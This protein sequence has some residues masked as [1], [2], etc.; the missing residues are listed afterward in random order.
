MIRI[1]ETITINR[2]VEEVFTYLK[3]IN[4]SGEWMSAVIEARQ[5]GGELEQIGSTYTVSTKFLGKR[6]DSIYELIAYQP[7]ESFTLKSKA[8]PVDHTLS[9]R[10]ETVGDNSTA[11]RLSRVDEGDPGGLFK[12]A[13]PLLSAALTRMIK[14]DLAT[15][16]DLVEGRS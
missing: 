11:T 6:I 13:T 5:S 12:L 9:F 3:D 4:N 14:N 16:K 2:P 8:G 15:L 10:C 7:G 1:E